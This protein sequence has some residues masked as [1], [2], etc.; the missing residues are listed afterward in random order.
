MLCM[1]S[2]LRASDFF[3][4]CHYTQQSSTYLAHRG[5]EEGSQVPSWGFICMKVIKNGN[6]NGFILERVYMY[7]C[8]PGAL[9]GLRIVCFGV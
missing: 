6:V 4:L 1:Q 2:S 8:V 7:E 5:E 9:S 3:F